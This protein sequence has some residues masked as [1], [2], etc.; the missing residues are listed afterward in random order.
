MLSAN[1]H[2]TKEILSL[3]VLFTF[4]LLFDLISRVTQVVLQIKAHVP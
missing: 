1:E 4:R 3:T 2:N